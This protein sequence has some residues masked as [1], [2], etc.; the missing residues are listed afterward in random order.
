MWPARSRAIL[1]RCLSCR[2]GGQLSHT[3]NRPLVAGTDM[4]AR[5]AYM[6]RLVGSSKRR[7]TPRS[8]HLSSI[9]CCSCSEGLPRRPDLHKIRNR[10]VGAFSRRCPP[11]RLVASSSRRTLSV[12]SARSDEARR[13]SKWAPRFPA[14]PRRSPV[15]SWV[16]NVG[17]VS[18]RGVADGRNCHANCQPAC[19][20]R[21][22]PRL[23]QGPR[24]RAETPADAETRLGGSVD[25]MDAPA[26]RHRY[27]PR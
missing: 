23:E 3:T 8:G 11:P 14:P 26:R 12:H 24:G 5:G 10:F 6:S 15:L 1:D 22:P 2:A 21:L 13:P 25:G 19:H 18:W 16:T 7:A 20:S 17:L 9:K 27:V 4:K